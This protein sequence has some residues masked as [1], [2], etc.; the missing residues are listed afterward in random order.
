MASTSVRVITVDDD[1]IG[2]VA[3]ACS[4]T[5][6][7]MP[8]RDV[9]GVP[10]GEVQPKPLKVPVA[11]KRDQVKSWV[12]DFRKADSAARRL[13]VQFDPASLEERMRH[14]A[15]RYKRNKA[16]EQQE[17]NAE[18]KRRRQKQK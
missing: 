2:T 7:I 4:G 11:T 12:D 15:E 14:E 17:R 9:F 10:L 3:R 1:P 6:E 18:T 8:T 16:L 5:V 13:M